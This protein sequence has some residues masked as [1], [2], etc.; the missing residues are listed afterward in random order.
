[1]IS[2]SNANCNPLASCRDAFAVFEPH[3]VTGVL[4]KN[5][6]NVAEWCRDQRHRGL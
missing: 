2:D 3:T 1:M 4:H 6:T 5:L